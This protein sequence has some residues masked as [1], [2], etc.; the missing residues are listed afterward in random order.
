MDGSHFDLEMGLLH[1]DTTTGKYA[2]I[3]VFFDR[4]E[5]GNDTNTFLEELNFENNKTLI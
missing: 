5:G 1:Y 4:A 2:S 3:V